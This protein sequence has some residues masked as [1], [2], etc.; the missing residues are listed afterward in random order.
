MYISL[1]GKVQ[2]IIMKRILE[3]IPIIDIIRFFGKMIL[4]EHMFEK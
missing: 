1:Q 3:K 2:F 4:F